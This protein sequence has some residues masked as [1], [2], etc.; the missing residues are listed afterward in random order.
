MVKHT[1][2]I[3]RQIADEF[4]ECDHFV[5]LALK[6][7]NSFIRGGRAEGKLWQQKRCE[8]VS[9]SRQQEHSGFRIYVEKLCL[10]LCSRKWL[11]QSLNLIN[12]LTPTE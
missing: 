4:F 2:T 9:W 1:Q 8:V 11:K 10:N 7:L 12:S 3:R 6:G 5:T